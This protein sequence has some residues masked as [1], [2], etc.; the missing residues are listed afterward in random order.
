MKIR[1]DAVLI[2]SVLFTMAS[3]RPIPLVLVVK[4]GVNIFDCN[5]EAI[6]VPL[7]DTATVWKLFSEFALLVL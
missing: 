4:L 1:Y 6:P 2:S 7:S 5:E 3:P